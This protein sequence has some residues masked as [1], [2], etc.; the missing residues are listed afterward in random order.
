MS[1]IFVDQI[2]E[3]AL[4]EALDLA[5][6]DETP[7]H[8][9]LGT[10]H[11]PL[12]GAVLK[13]GWCAVFAKYALVMDASLGADPPRL[14]R[15]PAKSRCVT[16]MVLE[17]AMVSYAGLWQGGRCVWQIRH[18]PSQ[19]GEHLEASGDLPSG[20]TDFRDI[21]V[22]KRRVHEEHRKPGNG[23]SIM[24]SMYHLIR[25]RR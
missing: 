15:L 12:A 11:V 25:Q 23:A 16:Y 7:D 4:Y 17:H 24:Y 21:A 10:S 20:F 18:D 9:D 22:N 19:G 6:T 14:A 2:D 13:S 8:Y 5:P 1:Y 3:D